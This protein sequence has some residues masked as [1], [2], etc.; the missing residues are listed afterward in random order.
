[1]VAYKGGA[2]H[3]DTVWLI[4]TCQNTVLPN[5]VRW[6]Q[7]GAARRELRACETSDRRIYIFHLL[8]SGDKIWKCFLGSWLS[9]EQVL[10]PSKLIIEGLLC[11]WCS[12]LTISKSLR[13]QC[14]I[15]TSDVTKHKG[16]QRRKISPD[17]CLQLI[18]HGSS[19]WATAWPSSWAAWRQMLSSSSGHVYVGQPESNKQLHN[20]R[21][22]SRD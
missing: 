22:I 17:I 10:L 11:G 16:D 13:T 8:A 12:M 15:C 18:W 2:C 14:D 21:R 9:H 20:N 7:I 6:V 1:M 4:R 19:S 3:H 5:T